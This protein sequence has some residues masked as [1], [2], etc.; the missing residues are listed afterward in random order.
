[1]T[2]K[3]LEVAFLADEFE[4]PAARA[5][6]IIADNEDEAAALT[7]SQLA[8]ERNRNPYEGMPVPDSLDERYIPHEGVMKIPVVKQDSEAGRTGP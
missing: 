7:T 4:L 8:D 3:K 2:D 1:M 5:A 6:A